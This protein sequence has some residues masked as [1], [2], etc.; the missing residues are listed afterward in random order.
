M[1]LPIIDISA[2]H[3]NKVKSENNFKKYF[4]LFVF[5]E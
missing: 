5:T 1:F 3:L 2:A 4:Q